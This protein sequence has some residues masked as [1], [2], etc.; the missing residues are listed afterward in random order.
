MTKLMVSPNRVA[1]DVDSMFDEFFRAPRVWSNGDTA[2]V[3]R[4]NISENDDL[5]RINFEVPG[6]E[7]SNFKV[8]I[9]D[10]VLTV[11]GERSFETKE[12]NENWVRTE[13]STGHFTRSFTLPETVDAEHV[14]ADY[15]AGILELTLPKKEEAKPREIDVQIS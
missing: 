2:F 4:V 13:M 8:T 12:E 9:K 1:R 10:K 11:S 3:P 14:K 5:V 7:K 6:M 15:K